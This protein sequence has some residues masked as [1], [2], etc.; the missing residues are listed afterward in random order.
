MK[1]FNQY[2]TE[3]ID[4]PAKWK[5][6]PSG[7]ANTLKGVFEIGD[8][9][10]EVKG[11]I[12]HGHAGPNGSDGVSLSVTFS[13][14]SIGGVMKGDRSNKFKLSGLGNAGKVFA[15]II[16]FIKGVLK[17]TKDKVDWIMFTAKGSSRQK[18][19]NAMAKRFQKMGLVSKV[20]TTTGSKGSMIYWLEI[21]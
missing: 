3:V 16:D 9:E 13:V 21:K 11:G 20:S 18:L 7:E 12:L 6:I 2:I 19:Y 14:G 4:K 1:S 5:F 10:Y 15:T 17:K 8:V